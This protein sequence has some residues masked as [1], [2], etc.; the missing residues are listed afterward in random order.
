MKNIKIISFL[1]LILFVSCDVQTNILV[2]NTTE[3]ALVKVYYN[4]KHYTDFFK[5]YKNKDFLRSLLS[6]NDHLKFLNCDTIKNELSFSFK[7]LKNDTLYV[8]KS[9]GFS[10]N[11]STV[12]SITIIKDN[13]KI[14]TLHS[15]NYD[16]YF[17]EYDNIWIYNIY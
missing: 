5:T 6:S 7:L 1:I 10:P 11:Y 4:R 8:D 14:V 17:K 3:S 9:R 12:D 13:V 15:E 16:E 2:T